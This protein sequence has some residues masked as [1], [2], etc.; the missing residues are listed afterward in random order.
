MKYKL[1]LIWLS[2]ILFSLF[3][4]LIGKLEHFSSIFSI[5]LLLGTLL[6][7]QLIIDYF[8]GL[9]SVQLKYRLIPMLWLGVIIILIAVAY[10][11][12]YSS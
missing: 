4:Y 7:G 6:K 2:L 9:K 10:Y 11:L 8:M 1:E 12:P 3:A 5:L